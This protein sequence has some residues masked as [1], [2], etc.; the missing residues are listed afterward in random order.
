MGI[1]TLGLIF[2]GRSGEHEVSVQSAASIWQAADRTKYEVIPIAI[3]KKGKWIPGLSP[4]DV[5]QTGG[6][7][8]EPTAFHDPMSALLAVDIVFPVLHGPYGEDGTMQ[9]FLEIIDKPY[10][11]ANVLA[12]AVS[13]DKAM[14]KIVFAQHGF[15]QGSF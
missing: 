10:V 13:M 8:P 14:A 6:V 12:S 15:P 7:V 1:R 9:G 3:S 11:G 2:G 5:L 4:I